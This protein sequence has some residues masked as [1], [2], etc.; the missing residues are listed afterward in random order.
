V[1]FEEIRLDGLPGRRQEISERA[2]NWRTVPMV[3][4]G[5]RFIG[6]YQEA[7]ELHRSGELEKMC[8]PV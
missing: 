5:D 8:F 6:G 4:I 2:G 3:F 7:A 1:D